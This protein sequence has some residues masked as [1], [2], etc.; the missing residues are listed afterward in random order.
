MSKS[1][2]IGASFVDCTS[3]RHQSVFWKL[4]IVFVLAVILTPLFAQDLIISN[5]EQLRIFQ[6]QVNNGNTY[7][8]K[9][10]V[11][12]NDITL[13][14]NWIPIGSNATN[15][16]SGT[17]DGQDNTISGLSVSDVQYAGLF[18]YVKDGQIKNIN[19]IAEKI[20][21]VV[22]DTTY[23]GGLA[24]YYNS[25]KSI[26][27]C[28][29]QA[30]S[31]IAAASGPYSRSHS[32]GLMGSAG[33]VGNVDTITIKNSYA[34]GHILSIATGSYSSSFSGGLVGAAGQSAYVNS[35]AIEKSYAVGNVTSVAGRSGGLVGYAKTILI[36]D[37]Y[38]M[39]NISG[40]TSGGLIGEARDGT[41]RN[42]Y[43][44]GN[45]LAT[46]YSG[47]LVGYTLFKFS[48]ENSS[49]NGDVS[50]S[51]IIGRTDYN[52]AAYSGGLVGYSRD[53]I[54]ISKSHA[55]G[56]VSSNISDIAGNILNSVN[57]YSGGLVAYIAKIAT[58]KNSFAT[59]NITATAI[60]S[61]PSHNSYSGGLAGY[62]K[63]SIIENSYTSG[64]ILA[65][66]THSAYSG[67][68]IGY[69]ETSANVE[70][71]YTSGNISTNGDQS[72]SGGLI[73]EALTV[74]RINVLNSYTNG[75]ISSDGSSIT[76]S[77]GL[78]GSYNIGTIKNCYAS[79]N[80]YGPVSG[81]IFG[82]LYCRESS[83]NIS[84]FYNS[85]KTKAIA[86]SVYN[87]HSTCHSDII[88]G[89]FG[90]SSTDLKKRTT[91][92]DW[93]FDNIWNIDECN[94]YPYLRAL[95]SSS[96]GT[97]KNSSCEGDTPILMPQISRNNQIMQIHNGINLQVKNKAKVEIFNLSG[98]M[99][100]QQ[101]FE[102]GMYSVYFNHLPKGIYIV[103][104]SFGSEKQILQVPVK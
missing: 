101:N 97:S 26:E 53:T 47:G 48:I 55:T 30:D 22:D 32:G 63:I 66:S 20:R 4:L 80:I 85:E 70:S 92:I 10:V 39:G 23:A 86:G 74:D 44:R 77:G 2:I 62:V 102:T 21:T 50:S 84:V 33:L 19:I 31:I 42:S 88:T 54:T 89:I 1:K 11:L 38:T 40:S 13:A 79:G 99:R 43:A 24:G 98:V 73:G 94:G 90:K 64:D 67:G 59:G 41:I 45:V 75:D 68:L 65:N 83:S 37:S 15:S 35:M 9:T 78:I 52:A 76:Y 81:G 34:I 29:V 71:S 56:N 14:G 6:E 7:E 51:V 17:F 25:T 3:K 58:I 72:Y 18:G 69:T 12:A 28:S 82:F 95:T 8:D 87:S 96:S 104:V 46:D 61:R 103:K 27:N 93:D 5:A 100:S 60:G 16:F 91:F 36:E 57:S 49:A